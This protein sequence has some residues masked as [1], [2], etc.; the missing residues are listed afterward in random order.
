[1]SRGRLDKK[2]EEFSGELDMPDAAEF[3]S[4]D[5]AAAVEPPALDARKVLLTET[6]LK[7]VGFLTVDEVLSWPLSS[8]RGFDE[9]ALDASVS[10]P[11]L[12]LTSVE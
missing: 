4:L 5:L 12:T 8:F 10:D 9:S 11:P 6:A 1:M 7:V 2:P 3:L